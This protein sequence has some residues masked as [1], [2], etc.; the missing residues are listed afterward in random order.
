VFVGREAELKLLQSTFDNAMFGN[1]SIVMVVGEPGIGKTSLWEQLSAYVTTRGGKTVVG[2]CYEEGSLKLPYLALIEAMCS[3]I[4]TSDP[5]A[6]RKE[7]GSGAADVARIVSEVTEKLAIRPRPPASPEEDRYRLFH[8]VTGFVSNAAITRPLLVVLEDLHNADKDTLEMLIYIVRNLSGTRLLIIGTYR[9]VEV[10]RVHPL[11]A[12]LAELRRI[13]TFDRVLLHGLDIGEVSRML[14]NIAGE[15]VP[16][17]LAEA[18]HHQTEGN[19][20]FVQEVVRYLIEAGVISREKGHWLLAR[21]TP[22][23]LSIPEG[24]RDVIGRRLSRLSEE[25][26]RVLSTAA[27]IG[28]EFPLEILRRVAGVRDNE[29]FAALEEAKASAIIEEHASVGGTVSYR[30]THALIRQTLYEEILAPWRIRLHQHVGR[31]LEEVDEK[32]LE[33]RAAEL[34][35]HFSYS[36]DPDDLTRAVSYGEMAAQRAAS[37]YA[38]GEEVR[39]LEQALKVQEVLDPED[40]AKRCDLLIRLSEALLCS[41]EP[42]RVLDDELLEVYTLAEAIGDDSRASDACWLA[43]RALYA[44]MAMPAW[45]T[46]EAAEW[47]ERAQCHAS[48]GIREQ[49]CADFMQGQVLCQ[50]DRLE[51]GIPRLYRA[52]ELSRQLDDRAIFWSVAERCIT[53]SL[54]PQHILELEALVEELTRGSR[55]G[56][57]LQLVVDGLRA[58]G[59]ALLHLG[60]RKGAEK[61]LDERRDIFERIG[62]H[63]GR[64]LVDAHLTAMDG[65][66]EEAIDITRRIVTLSQE[67]GLVEGAAIA[68]SMAGLRPRI[69]TGRGLSALQRNSEMAEA[70]GEWALEAFSMACLG[71]MEEA[72][73]ML[74]QIH[75]A[76]PQLG[77]VQDKTQAWE[78]TMLL[79]VA[80][81]VENRKVA[82][83]LLRRFSGS[84]IH[85]T[86]LYWGTCVDRHLGAAAVLLGRPDEARKHYREAI[87]VCTEMRFRPEL[88]LTRLQL[89][90]LLLEHYP[91]EKPE[92]LEHLDFAINGFREMDM[93]PSLERAL[94]HK[95]ILGA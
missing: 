77:L 63:I 70:Y 75:E 46:A 73:L 81:I 58:V 38:Y 71:H 49:V 65:R 76:R 48:A 50:V 41:G 22:L 83:L 11:S 57:P 14:E 5:S 10:D 68:A 87:R 43:H 67:K 69:Y 92:E 28:R 80:V 6:L 31:A 85:T 72:A 74:Q 82:D 29:V 55:S 25:C 40:K 7:L 94:R 17:G 79:E 78:D 20:L 27:V 62:D 53:F 66:L 26:N 36:S 8:A 23:K 56:I 16:Q 3:Y 39:L 84:G 35:E 33:E 93:Q 51:E 21:E 4:L 34:A 54:T 90:E 60:Q 95:E 44:Y 9:D 37:V 45:A 18:V 47:A 32:R 61:V 19:P 1:G 2:H 64:L 30:F 24:L 91:D 13:T 15:A 89:A 52:L 42:R 88:A 86:G 59:N 12:A